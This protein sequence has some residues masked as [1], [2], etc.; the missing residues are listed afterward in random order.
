MQD[1]AADALDALHACDPSC[2]RPAW[3]KTIRAAQLAGIARDDALAWSSQASNFGGER[4]FATAWRT[5]EKLRSV[6]AGSLYWMAREQGWRPRHGSTR[7]LPRL[8]RPQLQQVNDQ[9]LQRTS[10]DER[11]LALWRNESI[12]LGTGPAADYLIARGC[13]LPPEDGHLRFHPML[14]H[15]SGYEGPALV[16]LVTHA[17][18][19]EPMTV[20]RTWICAD[21]SKPTQLDRPRLL[22]PGH[23]K[24][25]GVIRLWPDEAVTLGLGI[26]EG[27]ES[28][29]AL[30]HCG[31]PVWALIDAGNM[32]VFPHL[33]GI[34]A[35][36][37]A[38][39]HDLGGT[40]QQA[41]ERCA[42]AWLA[43]GSSVRVVVPPEPGSDMADVAHAHEGVA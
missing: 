19:A 20:H 38:A 15:P 33:S 35:L 27:I 22:W 39:D 24:A 30:A 5:A 28:A 13:L 11:G 29:L 12:S 2:S 18:T 43:G 9:C 17:V 42:D 6:S 36:T 21:G 8:Q 40:G 41:A 14:R 26:A 34:E 31:L 4:D 1:G 23:A 16:A 32:A 10:L 7:C 37:I 25:G 3:I